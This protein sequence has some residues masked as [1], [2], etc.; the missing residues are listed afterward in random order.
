MKKHCLQAA[1]KPNNGV[2]VRAASYGENR[3][4]LMARYQF[5]DGITHQ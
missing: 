4:M 3:K 1:E 2:N 5:E